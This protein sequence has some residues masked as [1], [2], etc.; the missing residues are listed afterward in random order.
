MPGV[1]ENGINGLPKEVPKS[2]VVAEILY[3][4][5]EVLIHESIRQFTVE[6]L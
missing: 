1:S 6:R 5:N 3:A 2:A 4:F